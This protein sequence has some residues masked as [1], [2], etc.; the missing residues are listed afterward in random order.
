MSRRAFALPAF[1]LHAVLVLVL[2]GSIACG[3]RNARTAPETAGALNVPRLDGGAPSS[4]ADEPLL[5][6]AALV[7][8]PDVQPLFE[9]GTN[10]AVFVNV[11]A[12]R[13][14]T[15]GAWLRA[16]ADKSW[17][18]PQ[19]LAD[20]DS[21]I[22]L[23]S[24][25]HEFFSFERG[26][27]LVRTRP[28]VDVA[29]TIARSMRAAPPSER[30]SEVQIAGV[31]AWRIPRGDRVALLLRDDLVAI[32]N[33]ER[34]GVVAR[35]FRA[36]VLGHIPPS[37][38]A[39]LYA[40]RDAHVEVDALL[41]ARFEEVR[42]QIDARADRGIDVSFEA[43]CP[44]DATAASA[45]DQIHERLSVMKS[46]LFVTLENMEHVEVPRVDA[47]RSAVAFSLHLDEERMTKEIEARTASP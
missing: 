19:V 34:A 24:A 17:L 25:W 20:V 5:D 39:A 16:L 41:Y 10:T 31:R 18:A 4:A 7:G 3:S 44:D 30:T 11:A 42:L 13:D 37:R 47:Y 2:L 43:R 23:A 28:G 1:A 29:W 12:L 45:A 14:Q 22:V 33:E 36:R 15:T 27:V 6:L 8:S 40:T 21:V 46:A 32:T 9:N 26:V 38:I 35:T